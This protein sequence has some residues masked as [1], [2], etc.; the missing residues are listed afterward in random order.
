MTSKL[1]RHV[2]TYGV[3]GGLAI[4]ALRAIEYRWIVVEHSIEIYGALVAA[5]FAIV[6]VWVGLKFTA[7]REKV[8]V[9]EVP[10]RVEVSVVAPFEVDEAHP[11]DMN[12]IVTLLDGTEVSIDSSV[13][14]YQNFLS[15]AESRHVLFKRRGV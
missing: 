13:T 1:S 6:G 11:D 5:V 8:V 12:V 3:I 7:S 9:R 15:A 14:G 2:I 10:V 4:A